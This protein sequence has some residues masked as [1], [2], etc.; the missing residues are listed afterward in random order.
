MAPQIHS[1]SGDTSRAYT[2][3]MNLGRIALVFGIASL[4]GGALSRFG[5][6][7]KTDYPLGG[8]GIAMVVGGYIACFIIPPL[9]RRLSLLEQ[10]V[11]T[12]EKARTDT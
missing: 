2:V 8:L 1:S 4:I 3:P 5:V 6:L 9:H 11:D 10:R 12:L 7:P